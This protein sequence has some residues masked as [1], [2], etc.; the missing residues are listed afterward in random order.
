MTISFLVVF[1]SK[2][3]KENSGLINLRSY[4]TAYFKK[5]E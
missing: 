1:I 2:N 3:Y 5:M 4:Y